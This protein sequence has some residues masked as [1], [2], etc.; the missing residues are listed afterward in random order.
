MSTEHDNPDNQVMCQCSGTRRSRIRD[1]FM[2]G[3]DMQGISSM[4]G[5]LTG[6]GGCEWEIG[7]FLEE[8][9]KNL[10]S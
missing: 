2:Q 5:A 7:E 8:L 10:N 1:L 6:C 3:Q 9:A 4:T